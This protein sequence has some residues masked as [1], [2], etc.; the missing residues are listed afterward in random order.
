M[1]RLREGFESQAVGSGL[2]VTDSREYRL[3]I[4]HGGLTSLSTRQLKCNTDLSKYNSHTWN[5]SSV[6]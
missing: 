6:N 2:A 3:F 1:R 5:L 4:H